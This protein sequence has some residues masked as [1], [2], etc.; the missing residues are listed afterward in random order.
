M[1]IET[2]VGQSE[3]PVTIVLRGGH[4]RQE[5]GQVLRHALRDNEELAKRRAVSLRQH[6]TERLASKSVIEFVTATRPPAAAEPT[7]PEDRTVDITVM[8]ATRDKP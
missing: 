7:S 4:D 6:L 8:T 3:A 5:L 2:L 1:S